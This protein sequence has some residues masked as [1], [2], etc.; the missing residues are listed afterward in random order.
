MTASTA[1]LSVRSDGTAEVDANL[2]LSGRSYI[3]CC[4]YAD[5]PPILSVRDARVDV[6]ITVPDA[7]T[8]TPEDLAAAR[9]LADAVTRYVTELEHRATAVPVDRASAA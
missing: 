7:E 5:R 4:T 2:R 8:V 1:T 9:R 6:S 3:L